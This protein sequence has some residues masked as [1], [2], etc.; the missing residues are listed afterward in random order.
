VQDRIC[1][2]YRDDTTKVQLQHDER[3]RL[4]TI[5]SDMAPYRSLPLPWGAYLHWAR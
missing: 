1:R 4:R 2:I 5:I 3:D